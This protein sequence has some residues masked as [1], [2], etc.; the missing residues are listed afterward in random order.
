MTLTRRFLLVLVVLLAICTLPAGAQEGSAYAWTEADLALNF[1]ANWAAPVPA[2]DGDLLT[3]TLG[4]EASEIVLV[5]LPPVQSDAALRPALETQLAALNLLPLSYHLEDM[6]GRDGLRIEA[7]S[8]DRTQT[9]VARAGLMPDDR[10]LLVVAQAPA[11]DRAALEHA[12]RV[13]QDSLVFSASLPPALPTYRPVWTLEAGEQPV[14][15]VAAREGR[16]YVLE[17]VGVQYITELDGVRVLDAA[18]GSLIN[19][20]PFENPANPTGIGVDAA[21]V[22]YVGDTVCRC[23]RRLSPEGEW[24]DPI[25]SFGGNAPYSL[26]VGDDGTVY[27]VDKADAGYALRILGEPLNRTVGLNFNASAPPLVGRDAA[28][29]V[30]VVEWLN[31]MM[32]GAV[33]G[34]V[35]LVDQEKF[36]AELRFW[37]DGV[38]PDA[39]HAL[40][41]TPAGDLAFAMTNGQVRFVH[42]SGVEGEPLP[43]QAP[44]RALAFDTDGTLL[45]VQEGGT[46][47]ALSTA[48]VPDRVGGRQLALG[49]PVQ[50]RFPS[51]TI[52]PALVE[53]RATQQWTYA[54]TAGE[55][56][57]IS[58][59]DQ[60]LSD[61]YMIGMDM[62][63]R[64]LAP[65]GS[66]LAFDDDLSGD[67]LYSVYDAQIAGFTLPQTGEYTVVV[68]QMQGGGTY[69]LGISTAQPLAVSSEGVTEVTG[70]LQDVF[71]AQRWMFAGQAGD[72]LTFTMSAVTEGLDPVLTLTDPNGELVAFNDDAADLELGVNA[73][74]TQVELPLNGSYTL[75]AS[76]YEG[77]G[78]YRLVIVRTVPSA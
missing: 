5:V 37:L 61:P 62:A 53:V 72:V 39:V 31:S 21:G 55:T 36:S 48:G 40:T 1:P 46:L 35:S 15:W 60:S 26:A 29:Q 17:S 8:A 70:S 16:V 65:D 30:W 51:L 54:G 47:R 12:L 42:A 69:T 73:Q 23:V 4:G 28:G 2:A 10:P 38:T 44:A 22:V 52:D 7:V 6:Y 18:T 67:E 58:A 34:A 32:D 25:G 75:Q 56:I 57:T 14:G 50:G 45:T 59:V 71:P 49:V 76:R 27:A 77:A 68:E 74:L 24:L 11:A 43:L 66:E 13:V 41:T 3:L 9:G 33:S 63:L 78:I 20:F 64:L 19:E